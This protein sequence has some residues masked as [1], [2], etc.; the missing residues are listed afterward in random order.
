MLRIRVRRRRLLVASGR[1]VVR[2]LGAA[3]R[4][5]TTI[6]RPGAAAAAGALGHRRFRVASAA[7][8]V[9]SGRWCAAG[10]RGRITRGA[11]GLPAGVVVRVMG[12][13]GP[14]LRVRIRRRGMLVA[15]SRVMVRRLGA[16]R[17][18]LTTIR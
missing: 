14:M 1:V 17:R 12:R 2:R 16:A 10:G 9:T 8:L 18:W 11:V 5:L 4:W 3:R 13:W 6:R 15:S 7:I